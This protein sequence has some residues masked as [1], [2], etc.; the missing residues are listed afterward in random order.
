MDDYCEYK[1]QLQWKGERVGFIEG[2]SEF[3]GKARLKAG[4][5]LVFTSMDDGLQVQV[6][7]KA[8]SV[9]SL[10][11]CKKHRQGPWEDPRHEG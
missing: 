5:T 1:V 10:W 9:E 7:R 2:W 6:Y 3:L 11:S 4:D 8:A